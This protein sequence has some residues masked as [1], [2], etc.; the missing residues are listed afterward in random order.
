[1]STIFT[2][3][4]NNE[5]PGYKIWEDDLAFAFLDARPHNLGHV[6][7]V[8]KQEIADFLDLEKDLL[9]HLFLT[10]QFLGKKIKEATFC[11]K[12]AIVVEGYGVPDHFHVHVIPTF[13]AYEIDEGFAKERPKN[14]ME[15]IAEQLCDLIN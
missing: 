9:T 4:L 5:I 13:Y 15:M 6:L 7:L 1:M 3:I 8:P 10:A 14:E 12:I 11:K 2:K